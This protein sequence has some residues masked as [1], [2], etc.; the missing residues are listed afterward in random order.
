MNLQTHSLTFPLLILYVNGIGRKDNNMI[1][2][3]MSD[4]GKVKKSRRKIVLSCNSMYMNLRHKMQDLHNIIH[5][6]LFD[7]KLFTHLH[8][9]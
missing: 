2:I 1:Q 8:L 9:N 5:N 6:L 3:E 4:K 7:W